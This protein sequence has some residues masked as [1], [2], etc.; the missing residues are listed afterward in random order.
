MFYSETKTSNIQLLWQEKKTNLLVQN[1][2]MIIT[3][4][5]FTYLYYLFYFIIYITQKCLIRFKF[6]LMFISGYHLPF[7]AVKKETPYKE[8]LSAT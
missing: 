3:S 5:L 1:I 6:Q 8:I 2:L 4:N 7:I